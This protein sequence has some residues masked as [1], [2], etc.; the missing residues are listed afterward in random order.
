MKHPSRSPLPTHA[1]S[2]DVRAAAVRIAQRLQRHPR[3]L[4]LVD[5]E[6]QRRSLFFATATQV[7]RRTRQEQPL[8]LLV[9][10]GIHRPLQSKQ[11]RVSR[12]PHTQE[13]DASQ[14]ALDARMRLASLREVQ[15]Q[16]CTPAEPFPYAAMLIYELPA[17]PSLLMRQVLAAIPRACRLVGFCLS[18]RPLSPYPFGFQTAIDARSSL[19]R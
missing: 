8:L 17:E 15:L 6:A 7:L 9:P 13:E 19:T 5:A 4:V 11:P 10:Y 2:Q 1:Q 12:E 18:S 16:V 14:P 3:V